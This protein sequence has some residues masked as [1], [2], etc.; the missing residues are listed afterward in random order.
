MSE[1]DYRHKEIPR[2]PAASIWGVEDEENKERRGAPHPPAE[3]MPGALLPPGLS[4]ETIAGILRI[5]QTTVSQHIDYAL[6]K[7]RKVFQE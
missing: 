4:Q 2:F 3:G 1:L 7:L 6:K 5:H